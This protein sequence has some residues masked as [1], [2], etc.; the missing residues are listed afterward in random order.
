MFFDYFASGSLGS[1]NKQRH[2]RKSSDHVACVDDVT[3][4]TEHLSEQHGSILVSNASSTLGEAPRISPASTVTSTVLG[5]SLGRSSGKFGSICQTI[6]AS[7]LTLQRLVGTGAYGKVWLAE[8][9]GCKVAVK[10]LLCFGENEDENARAWT[11]MQNEVNMLG[12]LSHPNIMRFMAITLNPPMIV[13]QYYSYGSLFGLLQKAQK[14]DLKSRRELTWR[15]RLEMLRD[16]AAGM[17][18]L[19]TRRPAVIHGDLRSPN[20]LLDLTIEGDK[21]RFHVKIA[22]FGLARMMNGGG[23][24]M[25]SKSTNPRWT[26]PE[27]IRDSQIGP[28]GDV[29]SFA[30]IMWE[31]LTWQQPYEEMMSVQVI[32]STVSHN[33]RPDVPDDDSELPGNPGKTLQKYKALMERCWSS[34]VKVRPTFKQA[35]DELQRL[36][37]EE[38]PEATPASRKGNGASGP[39][40]PSS[41]GDALVSGVIDPPGS[42]CSVKSEPAPKAL[43]MIANGIGPATPS[44]SEPQSPVHGP[45]SSSTE[46]NA[47]LGAD[48]DAPRFSGGHRSELRDALPAAPAGAS[49]NKTVTDPELL[50][51]MAAICEEHSIANTALNSA[52]ALDS[53]VVGEGPFSGT[54]NHDFVGGGVAHAAVHGGTENRHRL[55]SSSSPQSQSPRHSP[56]LNPKPTDQLSGASF[57]FH[58]AIQNPATIDISLFTLASQAGNGASPFATSQTGS[59]ASPFATSQTGNAA[60]PFATSQT[61]HGATPFSTLQGGIGASPFATS[62]T[63]T[64]A[65]PFATLQGGN[66]A[67]P[68]ATSQSGSAASPFETSQ[69]GNGATPF[70]T[71]QGGIGA[72]PFATSQTGTGASP[73][74]TLQG[75]NGASSYDNNSPFAAAQPTASPSPFSAAQHV[76]SFSPFAAVQPTASYSPFEE[77]QSTEPPTHPSYEDKPPATNA[78]GSP[79]SGLTAQT[80][81]SPIYSE[82]SA[83]SSSKALNH[84][85]KRQNAASVCFEGGEQEAATQVQSPLTAGAAVAAVSTSVLEAP[86]PL[87][88][89]ACSSRVAVWAAEDAQLVSRGHAIEAG[90]VFSMLTAPSM[91][92]VQSLIVGGTEQSSPSS[93]TSASRERSLAREGSSLLLAG[94]EGM[95]NKAGLDTTQQGVRTQDSSQDLAAFPHLPTTQRKLQP[96]ISKKQQQQQQQQ[97]LMGNQRMSELVRPASNSN[98]GSYEAAAGTASFVID[99]KEAGSFR[100]PHDV[101]ASSSGTDKALDAPSKAIGLSTLVGVVIP[102]TVAS[103]TRPFSPSSPSSLKAV[104]LRGRVSASRGAPPSGISLP[105]DFISRSNSPASLARYSESGQALIR[106]PAV[107]GSLRA[108][109]RGQP[110]TQM[111]VEDWDMSSMVEQAAGSEAS[112]PSRDGV[113]DRLSGTRPSSSFLSTS[114]QCQGGVSPARS[115]RPTGA[116]CKGL[117]PPITA[118]GSSSSMSRM[119]GTRSSPQGSS[120]GAAANEGTSLSPSSVTSGFGGGDALMNKLPV[121]TTAGR[122]RPATVHTV[123]TVKPVANAHSASRM[124]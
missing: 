79:F 102:S 52:T 107:G 124:Q 90:G 40:R 91:S 39:K 121:T 12:S 65:S 55:S 4:T 63:G 57:K 87:M 58:T 16:I 82:S 49:R 88:P 42:G 98:D 13:M 84:S 2:S 11:D 17:H 112:S 24:I 110:G 8:W 100:R 31:M 41:H 111:D 37:D 51:G 14:G 54:T 10:E 89:D 78:G 15:K 22:D 115:G 104:S 86:G 19:H 21:P 61:G 25:L 48:W 6:D 59:A 103:L 53:P 56:T 62:Q 92:T 35:V 66:G 80:Q 99:A 50:F 85:G 123:H 46:Q 47:Q 28:A 20:L 7:E 32:F 36:R 113:I 94:Q 73:F 45:L 97:S 76:P 118:F 23:N 67:S 114:L 83:A 29:Y 38:G 1:K 77:M 119:S 30:I 81:P 44:P 117:G 106:P 3:I 122:T 72:S 75:G 5:R 43:S 60:S 95:S 93:A 64:G 105:S 33:S 70:S 68:F 96:S 120:R 108:P 9:T 109:R 116:S 26:A 101:A 27:V 18:Y 34:E 69:T 74:A 71:L